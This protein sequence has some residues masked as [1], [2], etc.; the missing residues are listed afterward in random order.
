MLDA[1]AG[2]WRHHAA[3]VRPKVLI[4]AA[5]DKSPYKPPSPLELQ[6]KVCEDFTIMVSHLR[7]Y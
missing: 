5:P 4:G 3:R 2:D 1:G 6:T 7:H